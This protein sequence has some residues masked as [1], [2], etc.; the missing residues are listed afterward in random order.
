[1]AKRI[2][3]TQQDTEKSN[4]VKFQGSNFNNHPSNAKNIAIEF[5]FMMWIFHELQYIIIEL[6]QTFY[7]KGVPAK[8]QKYLKHISW[9]I[10]RTSS[11]KL[12]CNPRHPSRNICCNHCHHLMQP[13]W[14]PIFSTSNNQKTGRQRHQQCLQGFFLWQ[15]IYLAQKMRLWALLEHTDKNIKMRS[16]LAA[17]MMTMVAAATIVRFPQW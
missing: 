12:S 10:G 13:S 4:C 14:R 9:V 17:A 15:T 8:F 5:W 6:M 7:L 16:T 1:M 2:T 3:H 11:S